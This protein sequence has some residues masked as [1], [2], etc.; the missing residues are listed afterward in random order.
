METLKAYW[1]NTAP[2]VPESRCHARELVDVSRTKGQYKRFLELRRARSFGRLALA[3]ASSTRR[4]VIS[5]VA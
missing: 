5:G 3:L 4:T 1:R 2:V